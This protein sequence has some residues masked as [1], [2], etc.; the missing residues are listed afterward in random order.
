M[1]QSASVRSDVL[2]DS[3][4]AHDV[5]NGLS[6][7]QKSIPCQWFYDYRGSQLFEEITGLA[8]YYPTRTEIAILR[9]NVEK[10]AAHIG[11][12][13]T[14]V[15]IGSGSSRKTPL[16]LHALSQ[17]RSYIPVDISEEF[18]YASVRELK[19]LMPGL[20]CTPI[21]ADFSDPRALRSALSMLPKEGPR[22]GFFPG[23]TIGNFAPDPSRALLR[24]VGDLLG[25]GAWMIIGV[26]STQD[27]AVLVPAYDD[28]RGV[29]AEFNLNLLARINRELAG[30][31]ALEAF[32]H[33]ARFDTQHGRIEMHLVSKQI[34]QVRVLN[35]VFS[36]NVDETI[37]TEN[38][39]KY[40]VAHFDEIARAA[41][42]TPIE[43]C[44]DDAGGFGVFLLQRNP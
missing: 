37:H 36:F 16:L 43:R 24:N 6:G 12:G 8:E 31:F 9:A 1:Q 29:T 39:Y 21:V 13:A 40:S 30:T 41:G 2:P 44:S 38:A 14:V 28:A 11:V 10:I 7:M 34:Q 32:A 3:R 20:Q 4:F 17:L 22:V 33:E 27:P 19:T 26:D 5:L 35:R 18:L 25:S 23:S 15:E 42:W